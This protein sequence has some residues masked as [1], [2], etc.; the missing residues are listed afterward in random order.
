MIVAILALGWGITQFAAQKNSK[1]TQITP[2][3]IEKVQQQTVT[4]DLT[5][6]GKVHPYSTVAVRSQVEGP[7][8]QIDFERGQDVKVGQVLFTIDPRPFE[9]ALQQV[10]ANLEREQA[11]LTEAQANFKRIKPLLAK[12]F[13]SQG[14]YDQAYSELKAQEANV[15]AAQ[16]NVANAQLQ[17]DYCTIRS[18]IDGRTGDILIHLGNLVKANDTQPLVVINQL[19]PIFVS[20]D[21][22]E[23][24]LPS[25]NK[26]LAQ[27]KIPVT[28]KDANDQ[29]LSTQGELFF[30]DNAIDT[31]TGTVEL[32][33]NFSN[34]QDELWPGQFVSVQLGLYEIENAIIIPTRA[35]QHGQKGSY[36]FVVNAA[37]KAEFRS[38]DTAEA[39]GDNTIITKGLDPQEQVVVDGQFRLMDGSEVQI[40]APE[41]DSGT[42]HD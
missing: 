9:V 32:K 3:S 30:V 21:V 13:I 41:A 24:F 33:A 17:L 1:P 7:I 16:A 28:A 18:P 26:R 38:I 29:V 27:G 31:L 12:H 25:I 4:V 14:E 39:I 5:A 20:F 36:V 42:M 15:H 40:V 2:V 35:I 10:E 34:E 8:T 23:K 19:S 11:L 22:P 6:V 37:N